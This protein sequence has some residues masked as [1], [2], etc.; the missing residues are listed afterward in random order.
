MTVLISCGTSAKKTYKFLFISIVDYFEITGWMNKNIY[1]LS[2]PLNTFFPNLLI[3]I[4]TQYFRINNANPVNSDISKM[5][6]M[7]KK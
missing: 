1:F 4:S 7:K 2:F 6:M 3:Y 5:M